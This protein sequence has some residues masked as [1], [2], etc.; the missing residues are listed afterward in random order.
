MLYYLSNFDNIWGPLRLF[1]SH[2]TLIGLGMIFTSLAVWLILPRIKHL[3]PTDRGKEFACQGEKSRGKPQG[4]GLVFI[5]VFTLICILVIPPSVRIYQV[6]C[7]VYLTMLT[8][9]FDDKSEKPWGQL[10]KGSLDFVLA[11]LTAAAVCQMESMSVWVP[12]SKQVFSCPAWLFILIS[13]PLLWIMINS[14]NCTDGVDGLA[15]VLSLFP[16]LFLGAF[17]YAVTGHVNFAEYLLVPHN[18]QGALWA[19]M[20]LSLAGAI[21]GYLWYNAEPSHLLMGDAGSRAIGLVLGVG[22]LASGNFFLVF[23]V[24]PVILINGGAGLVKI[25]LLRFLRR[26]GVCT[27]NKDDAKIY[28]KLIHRYRFPLHDHCRKELGWSNPQVVM[29]FAMIQ[30]WLLMILFTAL[31]KMR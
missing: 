19:I 8:G 9:Y 12:F 23:V 16:L 21:C 31:I 5:T 22:V 15:G 2:L 24:A 20:M 29:R 3:L 1:Q 7:C 17:L 4:A 14:T 25:V 30:A 27:K 26:A 28:I 10:L 13:V 6:L 18:P 11:L